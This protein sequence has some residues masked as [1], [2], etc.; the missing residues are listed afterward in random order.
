MLLK[1]EIITIENDL[2][3]IVK[4]LKESDKPIVDTWKEY[5]GAD[6]IFKKDGYL[7]FCVLI[8]ELEIEEY[9]TELKTSDL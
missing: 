5:L 6:K 7:Y 8:P 4:I 1:R 9:N 2:F 3:E